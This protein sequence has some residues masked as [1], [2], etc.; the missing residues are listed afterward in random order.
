MDLR[1]IK[2]RN[3]IRAAFLELRAKNPIKVI[4]LC[5]LALINKSTFYKHYQD[6]FALSEEVENEIIQSIM[7]SFEYLDAL[8]T[9]PDVFCKGLYYAFMSHQAEVLTLFSGRM[10]ILI[11]KVV[12]QLMDH[13]PLLGS[14]P[15]KEIV[16]SFLLW[17]SAHVL[18]ESRYDETVMLDTLARV[19]RQTIALIDGQTS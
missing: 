8:F 7:N 12:R 13:Y 9:H 15:E 11:D 19:A 10:N 14:T 1:I 5:D 6:I 4:R 17:G 3:N 18:M 16:L 2:T